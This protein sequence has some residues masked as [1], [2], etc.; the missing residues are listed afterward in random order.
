LSALG[1]A[2]LTESESK[3]L[4]AA[5]GIP[6]SR[7]ERVSSAEAAVAAA[8]RI[9]YPVALKVESPDILHKTEAGIVRL[10]LRDAAQVRSAYAAV[11]AAAKAYAPDAAISGVLVQ[12]MVEGGMEVILGL[13][14]D[15]Q[16]GPTI[17]F[18]SGGV[19]VEA[20]N[21]VALRRC[22]VTPAEAR[23]MIS[24]VR[25]ARLLQGFRGRP[26]GDI[27]ALAAALVRLS[28]MG[29]HLDGKLAELDVNPLMVLPEGKGVK[30]VDGLALFGQ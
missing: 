23:E 30:A 19:M 13:S 20:Y 4:I 29:V 11:M 3:T 5:W 25:G 18:G 8:E 12:E 15:A 10:T 21:D 2:A 17:L 16:L 1:R 28:H 27:E 14:Y 9:G 22:P 7:E 6:V 24:E 26:R